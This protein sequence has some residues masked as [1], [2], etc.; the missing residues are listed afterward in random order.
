MT[1]ERH[2]GHVPSGIARD[3]DPPTAEPRNAPARTTLAI[4][5]TVLASV[6]LIS[7]GMDSPSDGKA[8]ADLPSAEVGEVDPEGDPP[9]DSATR[10]EREV[11][12][13]RSS[14]S[15]GWPGAL[16]LD[17]GEA[18]CVA[19]GIEDRP[20]ILLDPSEVGQWDPEFDPD[21]V[22][23]LVVACTDWEV[24]HEMEVAQSPEGRLASGAP[25]VDRTR[26]CREFT[27]PVV[28]ES[29]WE[30]DEI[31]LVCGVEVDRLWTLSLISMRYPDFSHR[32]P[33]AVSD[34]IRGAVH[35]SFL[36]HW[37]AQEERVCAGGAC[38]D[39][40]LE[41]GSDLLVGASGG[42][43]PARLWIDGDVTRDD[44]ILSVLMV[45]SSHHVTSNDFIEGFHPV[46]VERRTG[47]VFGLADLFGGDDDWWWPVA[48]A[49]AAASGWWDAEGG[50]MAPPPP[51]DPAWWVAA[52]TVGDGEPPSMSLAEFDEVFYGHEDKF[53][54]WASTRYPVV[55]MPSTITFIGTD[56]VFPGSCCGGDPGYLEV[57]WEAFLDH[58]DP[59][60]PGRVILEQYGR[61]Y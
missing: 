39:G 14:P 58:L 37:A 60:G 5:T 41:D 47:A 9:I 54:E 17:E 59:D 7:L 26:V 51:E 36:D 27:R 30:G 28:A 55:L 46:H 32:E 49:F 3:H 8:G 22:L 10:L 4:L 33:P 45:S 50:V 24:T 43:I 34:F 35:Y 29:G 42:R 53:Y 20:W 61:L 57:P 15:W 31:G 13:F 16:R 23:D 11:A 18:D 38:Q 19:S 6:L 25:E 12:F 40:H 1:G 2:T 48:G 21:G 44:G 52:M 56:W